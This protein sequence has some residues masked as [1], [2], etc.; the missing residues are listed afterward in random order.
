MAEEGDVAKWLIY[1]IAVAF[2]IVLVPILSRI[3]RSRGKNIIY[4][5][6]FLAVAAALLLLVPEEF[7]DVFFR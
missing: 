4:H 2:V 1:A 6:I 5:A 7:Q 3:P